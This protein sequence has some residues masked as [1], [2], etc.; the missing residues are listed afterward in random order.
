MY[1]QTK[2]NEQYVSVKASHLFANTQKG[3]VAG[4]KKLLQMIYCL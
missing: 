3:Y 1:I 4:Q 2:T